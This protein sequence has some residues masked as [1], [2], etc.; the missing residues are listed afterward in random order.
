MDP[1]DLFWSADFDLGIGLLWLKDFVLDTCKVNSNTSNQKIHY[2]TWKVPDTYHSLLIPW[3]SHSTCIICHEVWYIV[4]RLAKSGM[5]Y[6]TTII[7]STKFTSICLFWHFWPFTLQ[8]PIWVQI[9]HLFACFRI[10]DPLC[11]KYQYKY[12][13]DFYFL[14]LAFLTLYITTINASTNF[15][16]ICL[17]WHLGPCF[18]HSPTR[19]A[20]PQLQCICSWF[21]NLTWSRVVDPRQ[22]K[23]EESMQ[24]RCCPWLITRINWLGFNCLKSAI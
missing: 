2:L 11:Y 15:T 17:F 21:L 4:Q 18:T 12:Q 20:A 19:M 7:T 13:F 24:A 22:L 10:F 6:I 9:L 16:A 8:L 5:N 1:H 23:H 3:R 14:V